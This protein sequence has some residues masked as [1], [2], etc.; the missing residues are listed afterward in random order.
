MQR[1]C[2]PEF[3]I[4]SCAEYLLPIVQQKIDVS[5]ITAGS[6]VVLLTSNLFEQGDSQAGKFLMQDCLCTFSRM[7]GMIKALILINRAVFLL[8]EDSEVL[9][10]LKQLEDKGV[11]ILVSDSSLSFY[12]FQGKLPAGVKASM[13]TITN[14][15]LEARQVISI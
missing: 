4:A 14:R 6:I 11:E 5:R 3:S 2:K 1:K 10:C 7:E 8:R 15:L 9:P 13:Y 12:D